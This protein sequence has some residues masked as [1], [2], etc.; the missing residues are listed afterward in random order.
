VV[1]RSGLWT[2]GGSSWAWTIR[3]AAHEAELARYAVARL[4]GVPGVRLHGPAEQEAPGIVG[5]K[6]G[7]IPFTVD[8]IDHGL[9]A[10]GLGYEHGVGVQHGCFCAQR[11][12]HQLLG[13]VT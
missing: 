11:Y 7:V 3:S 8:G 5:R 12:I 9:V 2:C 13:W 1:G 10:A 4:A 6:V